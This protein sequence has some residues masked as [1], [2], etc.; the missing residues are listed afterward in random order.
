MQEPRVNQ[1]L[2]QPEDERQMTEFSIGRDGLRYHYNGYRYDKW[3]DAVA[4]ARL[5]RDR[6]WQADA[7]GSF[8]PSKKLAPPTEKELAQMAS[9]GIRFDGGVYR[10]GD[11]RYDK[12]ADAVNYAKRDPP[13]QED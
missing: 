12:L 5:M 9:L 11:F 1:K 8:V 13:R 10:F 6:P 7:G 3:Q 2:Q 4:Y